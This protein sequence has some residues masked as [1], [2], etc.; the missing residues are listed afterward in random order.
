MFYEEEIVNKIFKCQ[1]CSQQYD[2]PRL[3][4]CGKTICTNCLHKIETNLLNKNKNE[5]DCLMC[6]KMHQIPSEGFPLNEI[7]LSLMQEK[8]KEVFRSEQVESLK[9]NLTIAKEKLDSFTFDLNNSEFKIKEHCLE[10]RRLV[11]LSTEK[12]ISEINRLNQ[13]LIDQIDDYETKCLKSKKQT[14]NK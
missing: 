9:Q 6:H 8:P 2:E 7:L 10:L 13:D 5:L 11:Q 12:K 14:N 3:L 4:P 1:H